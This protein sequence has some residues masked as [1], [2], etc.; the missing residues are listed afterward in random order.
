MRARLLAVST[1]LL[2][3][4]LLAGA[5][6][7][8]GQNKELG[9]YP[10]PT[11]TGKAIADGVAAFSAATPLRITGT[12]GDRDAAALIVAEAR[13]LGL[14]VEEK[15]YN[16]VIKAIVATKKGTDKKDENIVFGAHYDSMVGTVTGTYDNGT[17]TRMVMELAR[18]YADV[19][20]HRTLVFT[21]YNGEE[22][23][24]F[25]SQQLSREFKAQGKE[26]SAYL[27]FDMVGIA[28]PVAGPTT[29]V[30]CLCIWH[31]A[32]DAGLVPTLRKVNKDFLGFPVGVKGSQE[33]AIEGANVR[34][35]DERTWADAGYRTLRWAGM[36]RAADYPEYH[37]PEDTMATMDRVA[38][39][40]AFLEQ[41]LTNTLLS[42]YYTAAAL[43]LEGGTV[44]APSEGVQATHDIAPIDHH[45][46][47]APQA[48]QPGAR[49]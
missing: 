7:A 1:L 49:P 18:A 27:G 16:G 45:T 42:A 25:G 2:G 20:T 33:V 22:E 38:G 8:D 4:P 43:D 29:A 23:G 35:S 21:W 13:G 3:L 41:G 14:D 31:G 36:R 40:R 15:T 39:G 34:N 12:P 26:V 44:L 28:W 10:R 30:N 11:V 47:A 17:G 19:K 48:L 5:A 24:A 37:K 46:H 6:V 32:R 9:D